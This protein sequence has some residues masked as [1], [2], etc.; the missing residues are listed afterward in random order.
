M[1]AA[2][3]SVL[4]RAADNGDALLAEGDAVTAIGKSGSAAPVR[5]PG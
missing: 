5:R 1:R 3:V 4:R 2:F